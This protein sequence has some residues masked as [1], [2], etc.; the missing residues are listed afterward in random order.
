MQVAFYARV[1]TSHQQHEGT[2]ESQRRSLTQHMQPH[3]WS[4]LPEHEYIDD[5]ISG[6]RLGRCYQ[7]MNI[8][9]MGSAAHGWTA[10]PWTVCVTR[11]G[12]ASAMLWSSCRQIGWPVTMRINGS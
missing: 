1:S 2:I 12:A 7:S 8:S 3:G 4:L 5:G 6:A 10:L 9:M 11:P